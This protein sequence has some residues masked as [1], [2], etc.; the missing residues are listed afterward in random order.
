[1]DN[2]YLNSSDTTIATTYT[3]TGTLIVKGLQRKFLSELLLFYF[4]PLH[5]CSCG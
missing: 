3:R 1:L 2:N 5:H 4:S